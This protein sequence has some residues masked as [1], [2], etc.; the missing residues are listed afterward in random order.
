MASKSIYERLREQLDQYSVGFPATASG[1]EKKILQKLY[2]E[3]EASL[4]LDMSAAGDAGICGRT[5]RSGS[6]DQDRR[7][8]GYI[9]DSPF[10][11]REIS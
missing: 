9:S 3:E 7:D 10:P 5:N 6:D 8:Q 4:I 2:T 11:V 1:I